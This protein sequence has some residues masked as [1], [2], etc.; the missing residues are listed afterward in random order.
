[1]SAAQ[2]AGLFVVM[3]LNRCTTSANDVA[4]GA[5]PR[6]CPISGRPGGNQGHHSG[7]PLQGRRSRKR[8]PARRCTRPFLYCSGFYRFSWFGN[9]LFD[10]SRAFL[11][12]LC[13]I[14]RLRLDDSAA[15]RTVSDATLTLAV[16][17]E[18]NPEKNQRL[19]FRG[20]NS[21]PAI[22]LAAHGASGPIVRRRR[23]RH[24]GDDDPQDLKSAP[25]MRL[26]FR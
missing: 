1:M 6:A 22:R 7:S 25:T 12:H 23:F 4:V 13:P 21:K 2:H 15:L 3:V 18:Y 17:A 20:V 11:A 16:S 26:T 9:T 5:G 14:S 10:T 19:R 24:H 8:D